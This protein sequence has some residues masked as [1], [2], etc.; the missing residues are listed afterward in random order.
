MTRVLLVLAMLGVGL[1]TLS[2]CS[3]D[4]P[5]PSGAAA[6]TGAGAQPVSTLKGTQRLPKGPP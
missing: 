6:A 4:K 2:G 1:A 3:D 5:T